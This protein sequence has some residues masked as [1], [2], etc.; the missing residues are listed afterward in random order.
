VIDHFD[1]VSLYLKSEVDQ[2][3]FKSQLAQIV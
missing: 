1:N 2:E 3:K